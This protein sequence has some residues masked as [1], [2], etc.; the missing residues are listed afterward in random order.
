[1]RHTILVNGGFGRYW[2][3]LALLAAVAIVLIAAL[4]IRTT[5]EETIT[6]ND[7]FF[8]VSIGSAPNLSADSFSLRVD[9]EVVTPLNLSFDDILAMP[10]INE[11]VTLRCV[12]GESGTAVWKGVQLSDILNLTSLNATAKKVVFFCADGYDTSLTVEDS[13]RSDV[14]LAYGM[15]GEDLPR[16]QGYPLRLVVPDEYGYK[17][18]KWVTHIE[19]IDHDQLGYWESRGWN[20]NAHITS[21]SD[22]W[23][24]AILLSIAA[25]LGAFSA[26][27]GFD[28][29]TKRWGLSRNF[30]RSVSYGFALVLIPVFLYWVIE[31]EIMRGNVFYS[32]HGKLAL[33]TVV[34]LAVGASTGI[35][36]M[37]NQNARRMHVALNIIAYGL[38]L[39]T[40]LLGLSLAF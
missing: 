12:T 34:M 20:D 26:V 38:L 21:I 24:H 28:Q 6:P 22:W 35:L 3:Y 29:R 4:T 23:F 9:G 25:I 2:G 14:I 11:T 13:M 18:A 30:H 36:L 31:T 5:S 7:R 10:A 33:L 17:W 32:L 19:V 27:S 40:I 16:D 39:I 15:N 37:K 8:T 1:M